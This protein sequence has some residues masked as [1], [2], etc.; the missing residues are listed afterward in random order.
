MDLNGEEFIP[1]PRERVWE[2]L[3]D[4][5]ILRQCIPGCE[6]LEQAEPD[7]FSAEVVLKIGPVKARFN[8]EV[9]I[10]DKNFPDGYRIEGEGKGGIAGFASGG[11]DV[12]LKEQED[13]TLLEYRVDANV[14]GKIA[15]LG[16]RL[17]TSTSK[18]L[19]GQFFG[20]FSELAA[21]AQTA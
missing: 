7:Q 20:K 14:G 5:E 17:I 1:A 21:Q 8:G 12:I 19:A 11:A 9:F 15:Q 4:P 2:M 6:T 3:N 16:S 13:G 10:K 18:K